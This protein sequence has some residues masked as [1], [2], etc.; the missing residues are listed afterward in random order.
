M[1][2]RLATVAI[3]A[4]ILLAGC[5]TSNVETTPTAELTSSP[6]APAT[7][8]SSPTPTTSPERSATPD[9]TA[10]ASSDGDSTG[11]GSTV[12]AGTSATNGTAMAAALKLTVKGRAPKTGYTR[13]QFGSGWV[14]VDRNGCDTRNDEP[15]LRLT[16]KTMS[17]SCKVLAGD[18]QDPYTATNIRFEYGGASE[19]DIDHMV[20][21]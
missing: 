5:S 3:A 19:V 15:K 14:D 8:D 20:A 4:A 7:P 13:D 11:S 17:G 1:N 10:S 18:L 12:Q 2:T 16:N 21:L 9:P 6:V